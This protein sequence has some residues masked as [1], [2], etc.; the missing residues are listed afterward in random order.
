MD[1]PVD[2]RH[3]YAKVRKG[4]K[5]DHLRNRPLQRKRPLSS[6]DAEAFIQSHSPTSLGISCSINLMYFNANLFCISI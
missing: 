5:G 6:S 1:M 4:K 2:L 3:V